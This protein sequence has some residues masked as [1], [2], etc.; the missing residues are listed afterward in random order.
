MR[1]V[2]SLIVLGI[3]L[4]LGINAAWAEDCHGQGRYFRQPAPPPPQSQTPTPPRDVAPV[5]SEPSPPNLPDIRD[6]NMGH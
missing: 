1:H 6:E 3:M 2:A 4:A 5:G